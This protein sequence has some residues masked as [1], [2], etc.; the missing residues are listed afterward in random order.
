MGDYKKLK[1]L[2]YHPEMPLLLERKQREIEEDI[3]DLIH[4]AKRIKNKRKWQYNRAFGVPRH[5]FNN[6]VY[7]L[8][9]HGQYGELFEALKSLKKEQLEEAQKSLF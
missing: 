8:I 2:D 1:S 7:K 6:I 5:S 9:E 4:Q 3:R